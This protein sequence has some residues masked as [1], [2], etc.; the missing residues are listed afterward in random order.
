MPPGTIQHMYGVP[1]VDM[2]NARVRAHR[3]TAM[4]RTNY[5][6]MTNEQKRGL[7]LND[8]DTATAQGVEGAAS[9]SVLEV[10]T[11]RGVYV[12]K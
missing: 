8:L 12:C 1:I 10:C 11:L 2:P 4:L 3:N 7:A 6:A 9:D 5:L